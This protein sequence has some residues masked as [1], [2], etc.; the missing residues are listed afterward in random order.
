MA[1][2]PGR[3][4][5]HITFA[6]YPEGKPLSASTVSNVIP[7]SRI[8]RLNAATNPGT[9]RAITSATVVAL[10]FN[11]LAIP[12][13]EMARSEKSP[14]AQADDRNPPH[15]PMKRAVYRSFRRS[16]EI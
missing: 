16:H 14:H 10:L 8:R 12:P 6:V 13:L 3:F 15:L 11:A 2:G 4:I 7:S 9:S 5:P 1:I